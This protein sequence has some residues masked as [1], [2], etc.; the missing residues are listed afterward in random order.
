MNDQETQLKEAAEQ[1]REQWSLPRVG[2]QYVAYGE[3]EQWTMAP[4]KAVVDRDSGK[5]FGIHGQDY[6]LV[7]HESGLV[8]IQQA[9]N[10]QYD[11]IGPYSTTVATYDEGARMKATLR[12][13]EKEF[14][15]TRNGKKDLINPT[16]EYFN[17]YDGCWAERLMFGAYRLVCSNGLIVGEKI[18]TERLIHVGLRPEQFFQNMVAAIENYK[19]QIATWKKW[20]A[21]P[22][23]EELTEPAIEI[24]T[25]KHQETINE[26]MASMK[27]Q[28][29]LWL[30][31]NVL[32]ALI[33]HRVK[34]LQRQVYYN[35]QLRSITSTWPIA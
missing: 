12:F 13:T 9:A 4:K 34:S 8:L 19:G 33:T 30:F 3:A 21:T 10:R 28:L 26:E 35:D 14:E 17:S 5:L 24:F 11:L 32:T 31:F 22:A 29:T 16:V 1:I 15:V 7:P 25:K 18:F 2:E 20:N 6:R 27:S 23:T